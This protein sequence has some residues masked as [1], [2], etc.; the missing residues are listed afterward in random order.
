MLGVYRSTEELDAVIRTVVDLHIVNR[1]ARSDTAKRNAVELVAIADSETGEAE[2]HVAQCTAAVGSI[3]AAINSIRI[4]HAFDDV[5]TIDRPGRSSITAAVDRCASEN[6]KAA[7]FADIVTAEI[8][9]IGRATY[10]IV[11]AGED[12]RVGRSTVCINFRTTIN[13]NVVCARTTKD[14]YAWFDRQCRSGAASSR[15]ARTEIHTDI[16]PPVDRVGNARDIGE[17][18]VGKVCSRKVTCRQAANCVAFRESGRALCSAATATTAATTTTA[19]RCTRI[20]G[21]W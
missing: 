20:A 6:D 11:R 7:P 4:A 12:D 13:N 5:V 10:Q 15:S 21:P 14:S 18:Q 9:R 8:I 1:G 3:C 17:C 19:G 16:N 2:R